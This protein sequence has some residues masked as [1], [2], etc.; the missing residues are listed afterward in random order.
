MVRNKRLWLNL[1]MG[2]GVLVCYVIGLQQIVTDSN[3]RPLQIKDD[4][5]AADR[6]LISV[7]VT[8]VNAAARQLTAQ[9]RFR[10]IGKIAQDEVTP[11]VSV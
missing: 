1:A 6:A 4:V 10:L 9:L 5:A 2:L 7:T 3:R 8:N 11:S